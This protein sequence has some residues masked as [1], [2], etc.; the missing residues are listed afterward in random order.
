VQSSENHYLKLLYTAGIHTAHFLWFAA[1]PLRIQLSEQELPKDR[2]RKDDHEKQIE[3]AHHHFLHSIPMSCW[4]S[5]HNY[6]Y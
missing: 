5:Y 1:N 6:H 4:T 2:H 3:S